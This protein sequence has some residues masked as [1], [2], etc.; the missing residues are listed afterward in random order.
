MFN[1]YHCIFSRVAK[2][3]VSTSFASERHLEMYEGILNYEN[4]NLAD[5]EKTWYQLFP[6]AQESLPYPLVKNILVYSI[7]SSLIKSF[8]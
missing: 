8:L 1:N 5:G 2:I 7:S 4:L 3:S 6:E